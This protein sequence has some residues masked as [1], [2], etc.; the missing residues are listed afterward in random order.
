MSF[1][2]SPFLLAHPLSDLEL[3]VAIICTSLPPLRGLFQRLGLR[4]LGSTRSNT[5]VSGGSMNR[6]SKRTA[7]HAA[8]LHP[9]RAS[10]KRPGQPDE[11]SVIDGSY[12]ELVDG[13]TNQNYNMTTKLV[14][15]DG[16][17]A[18]NSH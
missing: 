3:N 5:F 18:G 12:L 9:S 2:L 6:N 14:E 17:F 16:S 1:P 10:R 15:S 7:V 11:E 4:I 8:T 13:K